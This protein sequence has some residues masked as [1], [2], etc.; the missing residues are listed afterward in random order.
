VTPNIPAGQIVKQS[1]SLPSFQISIGG[2]PATVMYAGLAPNTIGLYQFN[3]VV[4]NVM[5]SDTASVTF[6]IGGVSGTQSLHIAVQ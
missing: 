5:P 4:P 2:A 6:S 1:S 3:V